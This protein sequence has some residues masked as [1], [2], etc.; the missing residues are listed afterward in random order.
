MSDKM[1]SATVG[2]EKRASVTG[3]TAATG[4]RSRRSRGQ[5]RLSSVAADA[6]PPAMT[7]RAPGLT[8]PR[9]SQNYRTMD[10]SLVVNR[11]P[12]RCQINAGFGVCEEITA[13]EPP[14]G[15]DRKTQ[16]SGLCAWFLT[17]S[18]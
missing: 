16:V 13:L 1:A 12:Q 8:R 7:A 15:V 17:R 6:L 11:D 14:G 10:S 2:T 18:S 9:E 5:L 3:S 4:D